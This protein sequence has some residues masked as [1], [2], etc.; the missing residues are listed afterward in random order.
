MEGSFE[1]S[2]PAL[3][4]LDFVDKND[5]KSD[6]RDNKKVKEAFQEKVVQEV[7]NLDKLRY[8]EVSTMKKNEVLPEK[9]EKLTSE[10]DFLSQEDKQSSLLNNEYLNTDICSFEELLQP[11]PPITHNSEVRFQSIF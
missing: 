6:Y 4:E 8:D 7:P 5:D 11:L 10:D 1:D 9:M 2:M 3:D